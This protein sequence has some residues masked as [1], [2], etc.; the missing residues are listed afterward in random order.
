V[1]GNVLAVS[2]TVWWD[3]FVILEKIAALPRRTPA[4][5]W[6][7]IGTLE[8]ADAVS[9]ARRLRDALLEKGWKAGTDLEY[10]EQ[11]GGQHDEI[12]WASRVE[13]MLTFLYGKRN[14]PP[15]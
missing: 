1:F 14:A 12:S 9:A 13:G 10:F 15:R 8:G 6:I 2:P 5:F 11:E 7:D 4:R 3:G